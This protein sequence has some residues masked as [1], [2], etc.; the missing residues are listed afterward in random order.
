MK[1]GKVFG[2]LSIKDGR[3]ATLRAPRWEDLD[4]LLRLVN[5]LVDEKAEIN[6]DRRASRKEEIDWLSGVLARLEKDETFFLVA[7]VDG[8]VVATSDIN[9]RRGYEKHVGVIGI[10]VEEGFRDL[11]VGTAMMRVMLE[12]AK[13]IGVKVLTLSAFATNKRAIHVYEKVGFVQTGVI[14]KKNFKEG[15]YIDEVIM[16]RLLE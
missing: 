12:Q 3:R 8:V 9:Q 15:V 13:E 5:S 11:G 4:G 2:E 6:R 16:T 7:E 10:A 1:A 14:P